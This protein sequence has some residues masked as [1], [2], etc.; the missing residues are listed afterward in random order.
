[1]FKKAGTQGAVCSKL[2]HTVT[3]LIQTEAY[4]VSMYVRISLRQKHVGKN[5]RLYG[6]SK[7]IQAYNYLITLVTKEPRSTN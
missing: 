1:M 4:T 3:S 5:A 6:N 7:D 2:L